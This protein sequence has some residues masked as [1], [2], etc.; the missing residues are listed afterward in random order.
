MRAKTRRESKPREIPWRREGRGNFIGGTADLAGVFGEERG[1]DFGEDREVKGGRAGAAIDPAGI[2]LDEGENGLGKG[3]ESDGVVR[4]GGGIREGR[5]MNE[6]GGGI[7]GGEIL[8][9]ID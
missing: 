6:G 5:K 8:E 1:D 7:F 3:F 2:G 4:I 9:E